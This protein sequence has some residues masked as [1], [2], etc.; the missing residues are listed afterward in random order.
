MRHLS[1]S[2]FFAGV[3]A[4]LLITVGLLALWWPV[5][6]DQ[7]DHYGI[8]ITC[9]RGFSANLTQAADAG[10]DDIAGKCST[11]LLIRRAWAIPTAVVGWVIITVVLAIWVHTPPG[12][13]EE[14][15]RFWELRGDA[16]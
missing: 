12:S 7:F 11:A 14:S 2:H 10:G 4:V 3:V 8:Q 13:H 9:G 16:T 15:T 6:L 5:Y 1:H